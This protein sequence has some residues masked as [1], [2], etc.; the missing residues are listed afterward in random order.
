M[1]KRQVVIFGT[2]ES[3]ER[4]LCEKYNTVDIKYFLDNNKWGGV[5]LGKEIRKPFYDK[6]A[7]II[8]ASIK[9]IEIK[10]Q[11]IQLG[12]REFADFTSF[13]L[14]GKKIS[15]I[16]G[17]CHMTAI[18]QYLRTNPMFARDYGIYP[19]KRIQ[20]LN[21]ADME[22]RIFKNCDLLIT[23]DIRG[24]NSLG[25]I[26]S[27][28]N[29]RLKLK[30]ECKVIVVP[31]LYGMASCFFPQLISQKEII[32]FL[33]NNI[34]DFASQKYSINEIVKK[35]YVEGGIYDRD[36]IKKNFMEFIQKLQKREASWDI[37]ISDYILENY[38][39]VKLFAD[40][41]HPSRILLEE[42]TKRILMFLYRDRDSI[43]LSLESGLYGADSSEAFIY[44]DVKS[45]LGMKFTE[46][47]IRKGIYNFN[48]NHI[49]MNQFEYVRQQYAW[50]L[51]NNERRG[52]R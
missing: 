22:E 7:F 23:Q 49:K 5:F 25:E 38:Q 10:K 46:D 41:W 44:K 27:F 16:Y 6:N 52:S 13:E 37:K 47:C 30:E 12:Y 3:C 4:F 15:I 33:D 2:G 8:I 29:I 21:E 24:D 28:T 36:V 39:K 50:I 40:T 19:F 9:Y 17:N 45:A 1:D 42:I 14:Y 11:L 43:D 32:G 34:I 26:Y 20:N 35:L 31:H 51:Y 48:L 18:E